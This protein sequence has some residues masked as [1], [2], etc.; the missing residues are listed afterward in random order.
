MQQ[1][2]NFSQIH[3]GQMFYGILLS[4]NDRSLTVMP[5]AAAVTAASIDAADSAAE[6]RRELLRHP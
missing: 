2:P 6:S 4:E 3:F 1:P 5:S